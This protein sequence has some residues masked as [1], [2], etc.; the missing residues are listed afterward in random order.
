M[1]DEQGWQPDPFG[2]H[3]ERYLSAGRP[4]YLVRD[5]GVE[6][7]DPIDSSP[8]NA[9]AAADSVEHGTSVRTQ[10]AAFQPAY[11]P[12]PYPPG[13]YPP[14]QY[15]TGPY[16]PN[17][18]QPAVYQPGQYQPGQYQPG[19]YP[20]DAYTAP[21]YPIGAYPNGYPSPPPTRRRHIWI[22]ITVSAALVAALVIGLVVAGANSSSKNNIAQAPL[23]PSAS[24]TATTGVVITSSEGHFRA[25]FPSQPTEQTV[26]ETIGSEKVTIHAAVVGAPVTEIAAEDSSI[27]IPASEYQTTLRLALS[28]FAGVTNSQASPQLATTFRGQ[29]ARTATF[30]IAGREQLSALIFFY[31]QTRLYYLVAETGAQFNELEASFVALP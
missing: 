8:G 20:A 23:T 10:P 4:T 28:T 17:S 13:P 26:P 15:Q 31:S 12:T 11:P 29:P 6:S 27:A 22:W 25:R 19:Q 3:Q 7:S 9:P 18:Y 5:G 24:D 21:G 1:S 14:D 2:R 16:P 30:T